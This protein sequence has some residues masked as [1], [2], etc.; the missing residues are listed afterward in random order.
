MRRLNDPDIEIILFGESAGGPFGIRS[1]PTVSSVSACGS[2][3]EI[4]CPFSE[5]HTVRARLVED[6]FGLAPLEAM[7]AGLPV[8]VSDQTGMKD[9]VEHGKE[10]FIVPS[11]GCGSA[12]RKRLRA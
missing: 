12:G 6:G 7:A 1:L 2:N 3:R 5:T 9:L 10:G 11:R 8:I 4:R